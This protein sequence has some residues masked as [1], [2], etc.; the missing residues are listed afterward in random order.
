MRICA[1]LQHTVDK[2]PVRLRLGRPVSER[3]ADLEVA[4]QVEEVP[5]AEDRGRRTEVRRGGGRRRRDG[6]SQSS[7]AAGDYAT[8]ANYFFFRA[9]RT[10]RDNNAFY[11]IRRARASS[12]RYFCVIFAS[13]S[14]LIEST[15]DAAFRAVPVKAARA[16]RNSTKI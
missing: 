5:R 7:E 16:R 6:R 14:V 1:R 12:F 15:R 9:G 10:N 4:A 3:P 11:N 8:S 13:T 2:Y